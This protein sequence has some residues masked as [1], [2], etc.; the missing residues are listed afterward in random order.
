MKNLIYFL[1]TLILLFL[2]LVAPNIVWVFNSTATIVNT[3]DSEITSVVIYLDEKE[4]KFSNLEPG[5]QKLIFLPKSGDSTFRVVFSYGNKYLNACNEYVEGEMYHV[6][7]KLNS[8]INSK[9][10]STLPLTS[11]LFVLKFL[12]GL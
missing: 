4:V 2:L 7:A 12:R 6:E 1:L 11:Q 8:R 9:C 10:S 3:G 5:Q